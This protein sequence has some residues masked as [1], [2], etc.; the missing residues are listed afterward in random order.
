MESIELITLH[1]MMYQDFP[2]KPSENV[3]YRCISTT[4]TKTLVVNGVHQ[5]LTLQKVCR[6]RTKSGIDRA[7]DAASNDVSG[8][9][10]QTF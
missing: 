10:R 4:T 6:E 9:S 8:L 1:R 7:D 3:E 2:G 5:F